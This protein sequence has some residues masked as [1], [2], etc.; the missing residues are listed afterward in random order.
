VQTDAGVIGAGEGRA[1]WVEAGATGRS[2]TW[3]RRHFADIFASA[4]A[5][6][7][8]TAFAAYALELW[9]A[10]LRVPLY[11]A[12]D[13]LLM[14]MFVK[15]LLGDGWWLT[16]SHLGAPYGQE[17]YDFPLAAGN[18]L[19]VL[20]I[21]A[22]GLAL[23][24]PALTLNLY[25]LLGYPLTALSAYFVLRRLEVTPL[26]AC[27]VSVVFSTLP[28]HFGRGADHL[29]LSA[30]F[31]VP[32]ACYLVALAFAGRPLF[33]WPRSARAV[34]PLVATVLACVA[35]GT[36]STYYAAFA[37]SL[38]VA[39]GVV[40]A[41]AHRGAGSLLHAALA[42]ALVLAAVAASL[43]P[44]FLYRHEYGSND[45]VAVRAPEE[46]ELLSL[47]LSELV[48]PV[49][50]HRLAPLADLRERYET[51]TPLPSE[52]N[53][54]L[55]FVAT[56]G[57]V[58]LL[59]VG[60]AT[61]AGRRW[62]SGPARMLPALAAATLVAVLISTTGGLSTVVSY[63]G[64]TQLRGWNRMSIFI[65]FFALAAVAILLDA[66]RARIPGSARRAVFAA[67]L[68]AI[69][70][71][72]LLDQTNASLVPP[73]GV[74]QT[75]WASD[76]GFVRSV[77]R[78][79]PPGASVF[80]LPYVS[81]PEEPHPPG[82]A[83]AY[84]EVVGYLHSD[85]LRWS[86]GAMRGR[87]GDWASALADKPPD[88][89]VMA[90]AASGFSGTEV[91]T[92]A[93]EDAG[94][95]VLRVLEA[96]GRPVYSANGRLAFV[97][98]RAYGAELRRTLPPKTLDA[99][100]TLTL[101]PVRSRWSEAFWPTES[102]ETSEWRWT[103]SPTASIELENTSLRA[104]D[105][106]LELTLASGVDQPSQALVRWPDRAE[107]RVALSPG[108]TTVRRRLML[109]PGGGSILISTDARD[110]ALLSND[111]R[112]HLYVRVADPR[113]RDLTFAD[114]FA[115]GSPAAALFDVAPRAER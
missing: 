24:D 40:S 78:T 83:A 71:P 1:A 3:A 103:R 46:A 52:S 67:A 14:L 100:R 106:L 35:I 21:E 88:A 28:Y 54:A 76:G 26:V 53:Q 97:D 63:V 58:A 81:F 96:H 80:Q 10:N 105:T 113:F 42:A 94:S 7:A 95:S 90:I 20:G 79:L 104:R 110:A 89:V 45:A 4:T 64:L 8:S 108:G 44:V 2:R 48:L 65:A 72:A 112:D 86:F 111:S 47:R 114:V 39:G 16:N 18:L 13:G 85:R 12:Y 66:A 11:Y 51:R 74:F 82:G 99:L 50:S 5:A 9:R 68:L 19:H 91:D 62:Q 33:A 43:S 27:V 61:A 60:V 30:Y 77:E 23:N 17:L 101:E 38:L 56:I 69:P 22:L 107:T 32:I 93:Y 102:D 31:T 6:V 29:F 59:V 84:D 87:D 41:V 75:A 36:A 109:P 37:A 70:V 73:H 49:R 57:L 34:V 25:Y 115:P 98:L 15:D 92:L 55:G